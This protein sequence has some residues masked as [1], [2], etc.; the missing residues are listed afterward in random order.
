MVLG[1]S[2]VISEQDE[3]GNS[4]KLHII[5]GNCNNFDKKYKKKIIFII[6]SLIDKI[7]RD[8]YRI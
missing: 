5:R 2:V 6:Y 3:N 4:K 7:N 8:S 1:D